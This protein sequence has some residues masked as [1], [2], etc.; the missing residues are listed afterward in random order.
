MSN[1]TQGIKREILSSV[2]DDDCCKLAYFCALLDVGGSADSACVEFTSENE[3]TAEYFFA[4]SEALGFRPELDGAVYDARSKKDR[5]RF[6]IKGEQ[7][8]RAYGLYSDWNF[9]EIDRCCAISYVRGAFLGAGSC[10]VPH[11]GTRSGYHLE[12][13]LPDAEKAEKFCI[14]FESLMFYTKMIK[15]GEKQVVY[16]KS[17]EAVLEVLTTINIRNALKELESI[18]AMREEN[19]FNNRVGNCMAGNADKTMIAS[20]E[21]AYQ[22]HKLMESEVYSAIPEALKELAQ[23]RLN[24]P[25]LS[26]NEL[27]LKLGVSKSCLNHR[28]RKLMEICRSTEAL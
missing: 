5:I 9:E 13:V 12:F 25:T 18:S 24:D 22:I 17:K 8:K 20:A 26:L 27:A 6:C 21:Q 23:A 11:E 4:L 16:L 1:F 10:S 3:R 2:P 19:N 7:A 14:V 15:R 28:M